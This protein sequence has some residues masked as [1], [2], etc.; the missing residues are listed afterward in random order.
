MALKYEEEKIPSRFIV[1]YLRAQCG[2]LV[3][4]LLGL[5]SS[6]VCGNLLPVNQEAAMW[7]GVNTGFVVKLVPDQTLA[8]PLRNCEAWGRHVGSLS[9]GASS[10]K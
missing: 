8:L 10:L 3:L 6:R 4:I 9:Q 1:V 5:V 2:V 7:S